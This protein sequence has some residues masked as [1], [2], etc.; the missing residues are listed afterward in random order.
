MTLMLVFFLTIVIALLAQWQV[1]RMYHRYSRVPAASG[2]TGA[3]VA[4]E[5]LRGAGI[6][7]V[8]IIEHNEMLGDHYDPIHKRLVLSADNYHGTRLPRSAWRRTRLGT[9]SSTSRPISRCTGA[10]RPSR[11]QLRQPDCHLAASPRHGNRLLA[12]STGLAVMAG[13]WA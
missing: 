4:H 8:A 7:D 13:A 10:W 2:Y 9:P 6:R 3:E 11:H 1:R 5:I 12:T